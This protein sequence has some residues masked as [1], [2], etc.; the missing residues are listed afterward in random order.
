MKPT[1]TPNDTTGRRLRRRIAW[2]AT[3]TI[4]VPTFGT[5]VFW[6]LLR[7]EKQADSMS[8]EGSAT[9]SSAIQPDKGASNNGTAG[10]NKQSLGTSSLPALPAEGT[11]LSNTFDDLV[12]LSK[13]GSS[14][15]SMRLFSDLTKCNI[16][17]A[18][19]AVV[20]SYS[21][22][23]TADGGTAGSQQ[24]TQE[25][26]QWGQVAKKALDEL[27]ASDQLCHG[28]T[29]A[30]INQRGEYLRQAALQNDPEAMVCYATSY[31]LGPKYLSNE[32]FDYASRWKQEAPFFAQ[33][34]L[35]LG[36]A[37]IL[38]PLIGAFTPD[39]PNTL[40][41][42]R[43]TEAVKPNQQLAYALALLY[44]RL[45]PA[46]QRKRAHQ[47]VAKLSIGL[48]PEELVAAKNTAESLWPRFAHSSGDKRV[49]RPCPTFIFPEYSD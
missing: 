37:D 2:F 33:K 22:S 29:A 21:F 41:T 30:Q 25:L 28:V 4:A 27:E 14:A 15:A 1:S 3:L 32:W 13:A 10:S 34:A 35:D 16:R 24:G 26:G 45:V 47:D 5:W 46:D 6:Q 8:A 43:L 49:T 31:E 19:V 20:D 42:Y 23:P 40:K 38:Q 44:Q 11:P 12:R 18:K 7:D 39:D 36:Q 17:A 9:N 48:Q